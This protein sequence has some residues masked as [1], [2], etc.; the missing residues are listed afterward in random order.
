MLLRFSERLVPA[1]LR[2]EW[3]EEYAG[4]FFEWTLE[5]AEQSTPD[6]R[7]A[8]LGHMRRAVRSALRARF[9]AEQFGSPT[10][11]LGAGAALLVFIAIASG[12]FQV[13]RH[14]AR[15]LKYREPDRV[16]VLAQGPPFFGIR[17]GFRDRELFEFQKRSKNLEG[18][19]TYNW[20]TTVFQ[21]TRAITAAEVGPQ[22]FNVLGVGPSFGQD[23]D[24][25]DTFL[26][27]YDFWKS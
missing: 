4:A 11:C 15:P 7:F 24:G 20:N 17:L 3:R 12:G 10:F 19:A 27:S 21:S 13:L 23:L 9:S 18:V 6:S 16:V 25:I 2:E 1:R 26:A 8:L 14:Y 5:A 22:F